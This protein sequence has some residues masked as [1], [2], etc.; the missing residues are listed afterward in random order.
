MR[1]A[2][3]TVRRPGEILGRRR[4]GGGR[5]PERDRLAGLRHVVNAHDLHAALQAD[6]GSRQRAGKALLR[7]RR[8]RP[9]LAD[10]PLAAGAQQHRTA[11]AL[12]S[13][14]HTS[15]LQSLMRRSYAV[16]CLKKKKT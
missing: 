15:E 5:L 3:R 13:E 16:F 11:E 8:L 7:R 6:E 1:R 10:E 12:R 9:D 14:A 4:R 2:T